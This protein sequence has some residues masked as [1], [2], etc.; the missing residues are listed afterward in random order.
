MTGQINDIEH[1][2]IN[3]YQFQ[4]IVLSSDYVITSDQ[5]TKTRSTPDSVWFLVCSHISDWNIKIFYIY[6]SLSIPEKLFWLL[7]ILYNHVCT[8][9]SREETSQQAR[10]CLFPAI[11]LFSV[12]LVKVILGHIFE[13][14]IKCLCF[15][16]SQWH[17]VCMFFK[18]FWTQLNKF[19]G[20]MYILKTDFILQTCVNFWPI[21]S[22]NEKYTSYYKIW[23]IYNEVMKYV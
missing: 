21:N 20:K 23:G 14:S 15:I 12:V 19:R 13:T 22:K 2:S 11:Y 9:R 6:Q 4:K 8:Q 3:R 10:Q 17:F 1:I 5:G 16:R 18:A 7:I